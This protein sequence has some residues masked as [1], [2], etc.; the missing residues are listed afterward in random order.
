M[1]VFH[2]ARPCPCACCVAQMFVKYNAVLRGLQ[3]SD[4]NFLKNTMLSLCCPKDVAEKYQGTA[5]IFEEANG[6]LPFEQAKA[7]LNRYT[8]TLHGINSA[9]IKLGK[10]N[11]ATKVRTSTRR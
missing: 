7:S 10:L 6:T 3:S 2:T 9:V 8:T 11:K 5:K 4:N 1:C